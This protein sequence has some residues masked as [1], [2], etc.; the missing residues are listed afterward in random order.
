SLRG[1]WGISPNGRS[2]LDPQPRSGLPS[3]DAVVRLRRRDGSRLHQA[4]TDNTGKAELWSSLDHLAEA[5]PGHLHLA[6]EHG[7]RTYRVDRAQPFTQ[8]V[9]RLVLDVSCGPSD[10]V[11]VAFV[12]DATGSMHAELDRKST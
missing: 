3:A 12:V 4:R 11:D 9:N 8:A 1:S 2:T 6:V 10:Q 7:G 5:G